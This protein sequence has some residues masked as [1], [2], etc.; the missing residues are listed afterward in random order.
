MFPSAFAPPGHGGPRT[1]IDHRFASG[2]VG[3]LGYLCTGDS[4]P[5]DPHAAAA[6]TSSSF[7]RHGTFLGGALSFPLK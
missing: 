1:A 7:G 2:P 3:S 4:Q 6:A 5:L